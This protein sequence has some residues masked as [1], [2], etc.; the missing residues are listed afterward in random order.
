MLNPTMQ[1]AL[2]TTEGHLYIDAYPL[3]EYHKYMMVCMVEDGGQP[4]L[5][6]R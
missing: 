3:L 2:N 5:I 1:I 4:S 6:A